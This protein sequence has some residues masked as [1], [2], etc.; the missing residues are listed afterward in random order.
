MSAPSAL[1]IASGADPGEVRRAEPA[2]LVICADGGLDVA[3]AADRRVDLVVGDLDSVS[4]T[5]LDRAAAAGI[6]IE[7]HRVDKDESD[8]ELAL[9]TAIDREATV[10]VVHLAV[11][12]RLDHQLAN[13]LVLASPRWARADLSAVVGRDRVWVVRDRRVL[14]LDR[15]AHVALH[16][17]GGPA[18]GV[19]TRGL[20]FD[21][22]DERLEAM[23]ARGIANEVAVAG[24]E[25]EVGSGVLLAISSPTR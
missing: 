7:R 25:I 6:A 24:P 22:H 3:L 21:L 2:D 11:G 10:V 16:S 14:P 19:R 23:V 13:L 12:G 18:E 5:A 9:A 8:L 4:P 20:R 17:I 1:V 15:G